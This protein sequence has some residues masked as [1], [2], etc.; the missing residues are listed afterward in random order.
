VDK[1]MA[2]NFASSISNNKEAK[3]PAIFV[4]EFPIMSLDNQDVFLKK[5]TILTRFGK[6]S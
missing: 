1:K 4:M 6:R 3:F 2:E 5:K